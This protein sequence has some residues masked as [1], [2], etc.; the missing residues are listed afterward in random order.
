MPTNTYVALRTEV[1]TSAAPSVT[2][3]L[4]GITGYTDLVLVYNGAVTATNK[5]IRFQ[6]NG[7]TAGNYSHTYVAGNGSTA[8]SNRLANGSNIPTYAVVGT[9]SSPGTIFINFQNYSNTTTNKTVLVRTSDALSE[10]AAIVGMWRNTAAITSIRIFPNTDNFASGSTFTIYGISDAGDATPKATGGDVT[11]DAT[12]WYH[13]FTMSGNFVPNQT[14]SCDVLMISGGGSGAG[15][16]YGGGGGAGGVL[17]YTSQSLTNSSPYR[18]TIGA[19][20][21]GLT[22]GG[23][24]G[25]TGTTSTFTGLTA[26]VGGGRGAPYVNETGGTGGSGGGGGGDGGGGDVVGGAGGAATSGQGNN[27]GAGRRAIGGSNA[28]AGGGGGGA[29]GN[30]GN[31]SAGNGGTGGIG[32]DT[33]S[34]YAS[35]TGTG[36]SNRYAAGGGGG[37]LLT[38]GG[39][40]GTGG[41]GAGGLNAAG[42]AGTV[43]TGSGG[44]AAGND[45]AFSGNGGSGIVIVRYL[46]A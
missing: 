29:G 21:A 1:L 33:Y 30:G 25:N 37:A 3:N 31:A 28:G 42:T 40:G 24:F 7:D 17:N 32:T 8:S 13:T 10:A 2:F 22:G 15:S 12:Y 16:F 5:D 34:T 36:V 38:S 44:G 14:L 4:S 27:G 45:S 26:P 11:S 39:T 41:G 19:G 9:S 20:G 18:I 35:V 6:F 23:A 46:K 43:N